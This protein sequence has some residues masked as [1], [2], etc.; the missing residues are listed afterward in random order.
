MNALF[1]LLLSMTTHAAVKTQEV[2]YKYEGAVHQGYFAWDDSIVGKR[3][4]VLVIHEWYGHGPYVRMRAEQLAKLGYLAFAGDMYGKG[5]YAKNHAEAGKLAGAA[6]GDWLKLIGKG[7]AALVAMDKHPLAD[8]EKRA[9]VGYCFGGTTVLELARANTERLKGVV[10]LHGSLKSLPAPMSKSETIKPRIL[11]LHG[12]EDGHVNPEVS[13]F[14]DEMRKAKAD[15]QLVK[16]GGA[17]HGFTVKEAGND[18]SK[19]AAYDEKADKRSWEDM[20]DFLAE[21]FR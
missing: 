2:D 5:V 15:W 20:K 10:S 13:G 3:P 12:A 17:V 1:L 18:P 11:V 7:L 6:K 9:A 21:L 4:A 8:P 16:Y 19:G 14:E